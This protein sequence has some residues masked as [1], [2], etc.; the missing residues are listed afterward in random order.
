MTK[1]HKT[2]VEKYKEMIMVCL[3]GIVEDAFVGIFNEEG[4][5]EQ[6]AL[7]RVVRDVKVWTKRMDKRYE[8]NK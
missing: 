8:Q 7:K 6:E 1:E 4:I 3:E 2:T 5:T